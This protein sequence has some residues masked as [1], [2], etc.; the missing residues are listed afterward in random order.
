MS[1]LQRCF[2]T[3]LTGT[4]PPSPP[5][6]VRKQPPEKH[7]TSSAP[8]T[9]RTSPPPPPPVPHRFKLLPSNP[10][11]AQVKLTSQAA[12]TVA[13]SSSAPT[14]VAAA[15]STANPT[16]VVVPARSSASS[17]YANSVV[18]SAVTGYNYIGQYQSQTTGRGMGD[19]QS[20]TRMPLYTD[21]AFHEGI[22]FNAKVAHTSPSLHYERLFTTGIFY[23]T[24]DNI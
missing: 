20:D 23:S 14:V 21:E 10:I 13:L 4:A 19:D 24:F 1:G 12:S 15:T 2:Q 8:Q 18:T 3:V 6:P 16:S 17:N 9:P 7:P 11:P 22:R 5:H